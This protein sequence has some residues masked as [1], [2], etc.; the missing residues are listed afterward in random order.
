M[1]I[2]GTNCYFCHK[3]WLGAGPICDSCYVNIHQPAA[4]VQPPPP[5]VTC[6]V[7]SGHH[8]TALCAITLPPGYSYKGNIGMARR[9]RRTR[10]QYV[11]VSNDPPPLTKCPKCNGNY[12]IES[13]AGKVCSN[14]LTVVHNPCRECSSIN[15]KGI[16][17][18]TTNTQFIECEDC[19]FI[20]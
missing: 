18:P 11:S 20:E 1:S 5:R 8:P 17:D 10:Y 7:C 9:P 6:A 15:T 14:C 2:V 13:K 12:M 16:K 3:T 4:P 19:R